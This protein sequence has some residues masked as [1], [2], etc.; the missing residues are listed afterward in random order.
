MHAGT[1]F[2]T[3]HVMVECFYKIARRAHDHF[4]GFDYFRSC[5]FNG[6][7]RIRFGTFH[8]STPAATMS[9]TAASRSV[10]AVASALAAS[11]FTTVTQ[12]TVGVLERKV[13]A[14]ASTQA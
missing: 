9:T 8:A 7:E 2:I 12:N 3:L 13:L 6:A 14:V 5:S 10:A 11:E 1:S 4:S